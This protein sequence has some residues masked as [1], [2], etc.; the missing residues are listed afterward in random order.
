MDGARRVADY[1]AIADGVVAAAG[2]ATEIDD[3]VGP[4]T[5]VI[6]AAG[7]VVLPAFQDAHIHPIGA[8]L[9]QLQCDL[10]DASGAGEYL[11]LIAAYAR[12]HPERDWIV[13][14][15]W[16]M[17]SFAGGTPS[18][19]ALDEIVSDRPVFL[20]N[21]DWHSAWVNSRALEV[22]G[23]DRDTPDPDGGRI[24]RDERGG[25]SGTLHEHAADLVDRLAPRP[26]AEELRQGLVLA[27]Q[28]LLALG[29]TGWQDASVSEPELDTYVTLAEQG[30]LT[31][32]VTL[33]LLWDRDKDESQ[34][35]DLAEHRERGTFGKLSAST[36]KIFQDGVVETFTAAMLLPYLDAS[37]APT[38]NSG[39]SMIE[40]EALNRYVTILDANGFQV[41]FHAIGDRAVRECLD[42]VEAARDR[43]GTRDARHHIAHLQVV[44]PD[45]IARFKT[46]EVVANCQP[47]WACM[48]PQMSDLTIPF[49]GPERS[50]WQYPFGSLIR[51][52]AT[53]AFGSDWSVSSPNPLLEMEVAVTRVDPAA[54]AADPFIPSERVSAGDAVAA[55]T[56]GS[57]FVNNSDIDVGSIEPGKAAD[58]VVLDRNI[59]E[60]GAGPIG[61]AE[62]LFTLAGGDVVYER[63]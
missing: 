47:L 24:E 6:D 21:R 9:N 60:P 61:D 36:V 11:D 27:Q 37:G 53:V 44:H 34:L 58:V 19:G 22:A 39:M 40:P 2:R 10:H 13:G 12:A 4:R 31:A 57:S 23:I 29:I 26:T 43:N 41:H 38:G 30:M 18:A 46:L 63:A 28:Q 48:E 8:G 51:A 52:G 20:M 25:P 32:R 15:G 49:L 35:D 33:S 50:Q 5:R 42:A 54:R 14:G 45:D 3:W 59:F 17:D 62:V 1:V 7:G 16:A 56:N 55:F